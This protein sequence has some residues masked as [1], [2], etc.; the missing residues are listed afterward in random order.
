MRFDKR[1]AFILGIINSFENHLTTMKK[2]LI[3]LIISAYAFGASAQEFNKF[4]MGFKATPNFSWIQ[5]KDK[6]IS[7]EGTIARA[8][9]GF[10]ADVFFTENYAIGTGINIINNGGRISYF[11]DVNYV[12]AGET[13]ARRFIINQTREFKTRYI[14][15]PLTFKLRTN[16][17]GYITYWGQFG[18]GLGVNIGSS[19]DDTWDFELERVSADGSISWEKTEIPSFDDENINITD[20]VAIARVSLI[21]AAGIEYNLS[22]STSILAGLEFNNGFTNLHRNQLGITT[23][24]RDEPLFDGIEPNT[25]KMRSITNMLQLN[26]GILF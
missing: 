1:T 10:V 9:F 25:F 20:D 16:E 24:E 5:P 19:A 6:F 7:N 14:E 13:T 22:G 21:M 26:V 3:L 4:R 23:N 15:I 8:G 18:L 12:P 17:I 2:L 11:R